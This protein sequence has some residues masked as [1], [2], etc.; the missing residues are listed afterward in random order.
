[1]EGS[2]EAKQ[3]EL[4]RSRY[5]RRITLVKREGKLRRTPDPGF[6][7][8]LR[9]AA[10]KANQG[11]RVR[12]SMGR[13]QVAVVPVE[14]LLFL[15]KLEDEEDLRDIRASRAEAEREGTIPWDE[16]K[17]SLGLEEGD[18]ER[19]A[20]PA[21]RSEESAV[22]EIRAFHDPEARTLTV[23][24]G[25][26]EDEHLCEEVGGGVVLMKDG[27]GAVIGIEKLGFVAEPE[28]LRLVLEESCGAGD[29]TPEKGPASAPQSAPPHGRPVRV[30]KGARVVGVLISDE[31][32]A[33][34]RRLLDAEEDR[35]DVMAAR[36]ALR[37]LGSI[38]LE[39]HAD[40]MGL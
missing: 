3:V 37:E 16:V 18:Q 9:Q 22:D 11:E 21:R 13:R 24:F 32:F 34:F 12:V 29:G 39:E 5:L 17:A 14:D 33:L 28:G 23:W 4:R 2:P 10:A 8:G 25:R 15:E 26:P 1:V 7:A 35:L 27:G 20:L 36:E 6:A 30:K 19:T 38:S 40:E 31:D